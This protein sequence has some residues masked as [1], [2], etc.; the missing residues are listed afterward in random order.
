MCIY[1]YILYIWIESSPFPDWACLGFRRLALHRRTI[2]ISVYFMFALISFYW[3][4]LK[5]KQN[6]SDLRFKQLWFCKFLWLD[7]VFK[8]DSPFLETML[9]SG[10][11]YLK[12]V[13]HRNLLLLFWSIQSFNW[14]NLKST[15]LKNEQEF[16]KVL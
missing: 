4:V 14:L 1:I 10:N 5:T 11:S 7:V 12:A 3:A 2:Y 6:R 8:F 16:V 13:T 15:C 9:P